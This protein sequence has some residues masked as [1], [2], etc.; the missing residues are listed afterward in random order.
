M[1]AKINLSPILGPRNVWLLKLRFARYCKP[2][3]VVRSF[4]EVLQV[5]RKHSTGSDIHVQCL[6]VCQLSPTASTARQDTWLYPYQ[7]VLSQCMIE[8]EISP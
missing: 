2:S 4:L 6:S 3:Q 7:H 1:K 5:Q 8:H